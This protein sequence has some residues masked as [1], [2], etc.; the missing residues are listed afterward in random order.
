MLMRLGA[1]FFAVP[2]IILLI[3]YGLELSA[4]TECQQQNL[5]YDIATGVCTDIKQPFSSFYMRNAW[6]VNLMMLISVLGGMAMLW[7][8][9]L[10]GMTRPRGDHQH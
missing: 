1:L 2:G 9:V 10:R 6:L 3:C 4:I 5:F 7:G 8:M